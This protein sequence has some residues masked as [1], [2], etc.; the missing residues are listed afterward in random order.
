[1]STIE[2]KKLHTFLG[3]N[4][5][6]YT[7]VALDDDRFVS[8]GGD[9]MIVM[10]DLKSPDEGEVIVKVKGSVYSLAYDA[11]EGFLY[12]G[13]NNQGVH[14]ID[15]RAKKEVKSI[16][17]G[18]HQIFAV[19]LVNGQLWAGLSNGEI[20]ILSKE[21]TVENRK[22]FT[23]Q[24]V[25]SFD[26]FGE[27][28]AVG[29]S[30]NITRI[31]DRTSLDVISELKG[32]KNSVFAS[33]YHPSGKY[34]VSGGRDAQLKIWDTQADFILRESIAAH[35]YTINDIVFREDGRYFVTASMDKSIKLWDAHNFRLLKVLDKHRH[36]GH[37]N[38]VNKLLWMNYRD[39][40]VTCSDDRSISVWEIKFA[41]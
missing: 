38:S 18:Q 6:I 26:A 19:K 17:L 7:L 41:E 30:D 14:K 1:M 28:V 25:R 10:W 5:S 37:G 27:H 35:L 15:L 36:A 32:H 23:H 24:R 39:L 13:Q 8:A 12:V 4:D 9:G 34:L 20:V 16:Q 3:H 40:L 31:I 11:Q 21:L 22:Q 2:V 29:F 33:R